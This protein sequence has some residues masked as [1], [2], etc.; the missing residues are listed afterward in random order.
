MLYLLIG[1]V[2]YER[3]LDSEINGPTFMGFFPPCIDSNSFFKVYVYISN[4]PG[5][6]H[7]I[8]KASLVKHI[9]QSSLKV[10]FSKEPV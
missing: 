4:K 10:T 3:I 5:L 8:N 6:A 2:V 7:Y 1:P 9:K